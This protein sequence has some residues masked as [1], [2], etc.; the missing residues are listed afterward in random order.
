MNQYALYPK[1]T[2]PKVFTVL[3]KL[4]KDMNALKE[5]GIFRLSGS[6]NDIYKLKEM[7]N[8]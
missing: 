4:L 2:V 6:L 5:Q 1:E 7:L 8:K 3:E